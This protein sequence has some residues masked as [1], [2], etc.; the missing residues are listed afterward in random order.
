MRLTNLLPRQNRRKQMSRSLGS[1]TC[2]CFKHARPVLPANSNTCGLF[3]I[4]EGP[5]AYVHSPFYYPKRV[6]GTLLSYN[7]QQRLL[8][9]T[10]RF[11]L[12]CRAEGEASGLRIDYSH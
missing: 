12:S 11:T 10:D 3:H 8:T 1:S 2:L 5:Q 7:S 9:Q 4:Q 6:V